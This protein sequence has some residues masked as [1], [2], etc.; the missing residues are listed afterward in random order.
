MSDE[1]RSASPVSPNGFLSPPNASGSGTPPPPH[2][3]RPFLHPTVSRLRSTTPQASR[4]PSAAGAHN[5]PVE[6]VS[7]VHSHFSD[8]SRHTDNARD[9]ASQ[10]NGKPEEEREVFRWTE[11]HTIGDYLYRNAAPSSKAAAVLGTPEVG[12]PTVLTANGL[13]CVGTDVGRILVFDFKQNLMCVCGEDSQLGAVTALAL[14]F[15][16]TFVAAGHATGYIQ[17]YNL[18]NP[19]SPARFVAPTSMAAVASGRQE[20]HLLGSR[21]VSIGFVAGRHTAVVSADE[22]GLAFYHSL[23][24]V[25]FVEASDILRILGKYPDDTMPDTVP[26][27]TMA[28]PTPYQHT[29]RRRKQRKVNTILSMA[30]L[31]LGTLAHPTDTYN[32]IALLTPVKLVIVG[33]RPTPRT[34]YRQHR[35]SEDDVP[36]KSRFKGSLAWFPS[37]AA[38]EKEELNPASHKQ[39]GTSSQPL[40]PVLAYS[41]GNT[42]R[43]IRVFETRVTEKVKNP[44]NGKISTVESGRIV[45]EEGGHWN[46]EGDILLLQWLN[47]NQLLILTAGTLEVYDVRTLKLVDKV[48]FESWALVSPVLSHTTNGSI[49]YSD[50]VTEVAHSIRVYK[51]KIFC[52]G[53]HNISVGTLLTWADR[54]LTFVSHGDFLSAIN[55]TLTYYT[56]KARG[57]RNGLPEKPEDIRVVIGGKLRELMVASASYAFSEERL[58]DGTHVTPDGRGVD[59]TDL[60]EGLVVS[61]ARACIA[62]ADFDFLFEELYQYYFENGITRMF[63]LQLEPFI[64][65]NSTHQVP[66]RITQLLIA[67]HH[68]DS[69]PDLVERV[70]WHIDPDC[71]DIEQA[72]TLCQSYRLYDALIYVY[73]RAM[74]DYV[75]PVVELMGL[76]RKIN[77]RR[78][79]LV[80]GS[81]TFVTP[82]TDDAMEA[83]I[84]NAYKIYPY[85]ANTLTGLTYPS[86][87]PLPEDEAFRAKDSVYRFLFF[88]RS[89]VWPEDEGGKLVL[90][91]DDEI[92]DEPTYPYTRLLLRFD[93]EAFLH[94]LDIAFEDSILNDEKR[95]VNRLVIT[96]ILFEILSTSSL[97]PSDATFINIFIARNVPTYSQYI[98]LTPSA[99]QGILIGLAESHDED[100][101][102]DRQLAAEYLLSAYTPHDSHHILH[103]FELAGFYRILRSW[104][105]TEQQWIPLIQTYLQ[106]PDYPPQEVFSSIQDVITTVTRLNKGTLPLE[107]LSTI[108]ESLPRLLQINIP[109]TASFLDKLIPDL[110][111]EALAALGPDAH[112]QRFTYLRYLLGSPYSQE[113]SAES[114]EYHR[115]GPPSTHAPSP[116]RQEYLSLLCQQDPSNVIRELE[117]LPADCINWEKVLETCEQYRVYD[118]VIWSLNYR[119]DPIASVA[120]AASLDRALSTDVVHAL[121][122]DVPQ[123]DKLEALLDS[124]QTVARAAVAVCQGHSQVVD[125]DVPL[126]NLWFTVLESQIAAVHKVSVCCS[127]EA[128]SAVPIAQAKTADSDAPPTSTDLERKAIETLRSLVQTTFTTLMS[129]STTKAKQTVSFPVLFKRL[130]S[131]AAAS[132]QGAVYDEF[133]VILTGMLESYRSDGDLLGITRQ[134]LER[135]FYEV[136]EECS[137]ER[138]RGWGPAMGDKRRCW[139]CRKTVFK[140]EG[141]QGGKVVV[142]RTGAI[143]HDRCLPPDF[144]A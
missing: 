139:G 130:V 47:A 22:T 65:D 128:S 26:T 129:V 124:L 86:E 96:K 32:L 4:V 42:L 10:T 28:L 76:I 59:R 100:T 39:N 17:L 74:K 113:T 48:P 144:D 136:V 138:I 20:G 118:A 69:R 56:G 34:W 61:C 24:K 105:R 142:S 73:T 88:G 135:D 11:L 112:D 14:S 13:I 91:S 106:D 37:V 79:A 103:L 15:D 99:L 63:L 89:R 85:L 41:W 127:R 119:G 8:L 23:G 43:L 107:V 123:A 117:Y 16:H 95:S 7:A 104:H 137:R 90:T 132:G 102:E 70:I 143:Y 44:K 120:K 45:F 36:A 49:S 133:R 110:H 93:A 5:I 2:L 111:E 140:E 18:K 84:M 52:L 87:R 53:Q 68:E 71:L 101:R 35:E 83:D 67:L 116:L 29:F 131:G 81:P 51:G 25:L 77:Q 55:L 115:V 6:D 40:A 27:P 141:D 134:I 92:G 126:D 38:S 9:T 64:L 33:L 54:I 31:P 98:H 94:T 60:F 57:N 121:K 114:G 1:S 58:T 109:R 72:I 19:K 50:A 62:L 3:R 46:T 12:S 30:P 75:A 125:S 122:Q 21:I 66:P 97:S 82:A 78:R 80:M 108:E